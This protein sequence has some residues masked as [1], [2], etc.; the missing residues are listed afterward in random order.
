MPHIKHFQPL[1][2]I[3]NNYD[4]LLRFEANQDDMRQK[5]AAKFER[6][7][8]Y[9]LEKLRFDP[10]MTLDAA[11]AQARQEYA[12]FEYLL[13]VNRNLAR[14]KTD[15]VRPDADY[16]VHVFDTWITRLLDI[17]GCDTEAELAKNPY[18]KKQYAACR[19]YRFQFSLPGWVEQMPATVPTF[20]TKH[21]NDH[22]LR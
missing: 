19:Y 8:G 16:A 10:N 15:N 14:G 22:P 11:F 7:C 2:D 3:A 5:D 6:L 20:A 1:A 13:S 18:F 9:E 21:G 17:T 12:V 4:W